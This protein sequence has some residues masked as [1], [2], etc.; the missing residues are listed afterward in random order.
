MK[1]IAISSFLTVFLALSS[2]ARAQ[3]P[4]APPPAPAQTELGTQQL[5]R[6]DEKNPKAALQMSLITTGAGVGLLIGGLHQDN[7]TAT[8]AG[9][10]AVLIGPSVGSFYAGETGRG[11]VQVSLRAAA[12]GITAFAYSD[13]FQCFSLYPDD[14]I[15]C[16]TQPSNRLLVTGLALG[17]ASTI[18]SLREA[19]RAARR[20]NAKARA[21][22]L[23]IMPAAIAGPSETTGFGLQLGGRF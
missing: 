19:P 16:T 3:A 22:Q 18:Y 12:A 10:F 1:N 6:S 17:A 8:S 14:E 11:V 15:E 23:T 21:R 20:Y 7:R 2:F 13:R 9:L 5:A 4:P